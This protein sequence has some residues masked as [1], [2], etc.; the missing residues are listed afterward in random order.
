MALT[1]EQQ[2]KVREFVV[3]M[4]AKKPIAIVDA[5]YDGRGQALC[6]AV[7]G[8]SHHISPWGDIEPCPIVQFTK[9]SI[10]DERGPARAIRESGVRQD[11]REL[12]AGA[13]RACVGPEGPE[14]LA[15]L[16]EKH[17]A[18]DSTARKQAMAELRA[19]EPRPSQYNPANCIPEKSWAYR[20]AKKF[21]FNDFG[22]Y[23]NPRS[24][25]EILGEFFPKGDPAASKPTS[26]LELPVIS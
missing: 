13:T 3:N 21:W 5:Y 20:L 7:T 24:A 6:P 2:L 12:S 11:F 10:Y 26:G 19:M 18:T 23:A 17:S 4:R 25:E 14:L 22:A 1:P 15:G 16:M 8:I 9:E